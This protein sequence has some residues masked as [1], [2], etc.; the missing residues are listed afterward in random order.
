M[1]DDRYVP[2]LDGAAEARRHASTVLMFAGLAAGDAYADSAQRIG[3][4]SQTSLAITEGALRAY[5]RFRNGKQPVLQAQLL[6]ALLRWGA[7]QGLE[8]R[9]EAASGARAVG[10][11][12]RQPAMRRK[13][14]RGN[15]TRAALVAVAN[16]EQLEATNGSKG[17][18]CL[19]RAAACSMLY[20][21]GSALQGTWEAGAE[22]AAITHGHPVAHVAAGVFATT[23]RLVREGADPTGAAFRALEVAPGQN[24]VEAEAAITEVAAALQRAADRSSG[25]GRYDSVA[26]FGSW[27]GRTAEEALAIAVWAVQR[28]GSLSDVLRRATNHAGERHATGA[29]AGALWGALAGRDHAER[30]VHMTAFDAPAPHPL[31]E[32]PEDLRPRSD[33][34]ALVETVAEDAVRILRTGSAI[35]HA[36]R[37]RWPGW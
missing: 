3:E 35:E 16:V 6:L 36:D 5:V 22:S 37:V 26:Q 7:G 20:P 32:L 2:A 28:G 10:W 18:A 30:A 25:G 8:L 34:M 13:R 1:F 17:S 11:L 9:E 14:P 19:P 29:A 31:D 33:E 15:T 21:G 12:G 23:L 4:I 27:S 24:A